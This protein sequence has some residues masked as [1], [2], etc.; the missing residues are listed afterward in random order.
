MKNADSW[1]PLFRQ[2]VSLIEQAKVIDHWT[3]GGG[4]AMML[5]IAHRDSFDVDIF[6][7]DPQLLPYLDPAR[8]DFE[9]QLTPDAYSGDGTQYLK[10]AYAGQGEIDFIIGQSLSPVPYNL[11]EVEGVR[12]RLET[13]Q[14][15]I[16]K[17]V[18]YRGKSIKVRDIF[19]IAAAA[20]DHEKPVIEALAAY[21]E[22]VQNA[23]KATEKLSTDFVAAYIRDLDIRPEFK[24]VSSTAVDRALSVLKAAKSSQ[25]S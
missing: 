8:N 11:V 3:F 12:T 17:K 2:A 18:V 10:I 9:F 14:E 16:T 6:L 15:I 24:E 22:A 13:I 25:A 23:I 20:R 5:Q 7:D 21:P 19:D 1:R 4:T